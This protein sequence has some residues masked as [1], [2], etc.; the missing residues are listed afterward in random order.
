M[1]AVLESLSTDDLD[2][3]LLT[4]ED[5]KIQLRK[6]HPDDSD[7]RT[8]VVENY[9]QTSPYASWEHLGD[10]YLRVMQSVLQAVND[11]VKPDEGDY[12]IVF[13]CSCTD[14]D[15]SSHDRSDAKFN[16]EIQFFSMV[17]I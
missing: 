2:Y 15:Y 4:R 12:I 16:I 5:K 6:L 14:F 17:W 8:A 1:L 9:L 3:I 11:R 13:T 7:F 10:R